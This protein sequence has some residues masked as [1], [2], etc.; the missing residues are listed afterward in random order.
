MT[1]T[2]NLLRTAVF[3]EFV[4]RHP[5]ATDA[6]LAAWAHWVN[7]ATGRGALG[8]PGAIGSELSTVIF[9]PRFAISRL[10]APFVIF[11]HWKEP[12]VRRE[13]AKDYAATV[14]FSMTALALA[15]MAGADAGDDPRSPNFGKIRVGDTR[16]DLWGGM[17]QPARLATRLVLGA[18]DR[19]GITGAGLPESEKA[20]DPLEVLG[21][22]AAFKLSPFVTVPVELYRGKTAVGEPRTPT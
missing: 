7:V 20:L 3:D 16:I 18:T 4:E 10:Q 15:A 6:E 19:A 1:T 22:F 2:L 21:Q 11:Q 13:I 14:A 8:R 9:A 12:R 5:N 17:V